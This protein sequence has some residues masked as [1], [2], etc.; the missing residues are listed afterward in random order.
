MSSNRNKPVLT[1]PAGIAVYPSLNKPDTKFDNAGKYKVKVRIPKDD[2]GAFLK[3]LKKLYTD[4]YKAQCEKEGKE[5]KKAPVPWTIVEE[6]G[7]KTG[8]IMFNFAMKARGTGRD[9]STWEN[10]PKIFGP[11]ASL[12]ANDA[13]PNI[14]GG[15]KMKVNHMVDGWYSAAI[16]AGI[17][18]RIR[19]VQIIELVEWGG[20]SSASDFGFE[21]EG[22]A[23]E[24]KVTTSTEDDTFE[25]TSDADF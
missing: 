25:D 3:E 22:E 18:L 9:G 6:D 23:I 16:G 20:G 14:G 7:K 10:R 8:E 15:T 1:C 21:S 4:N 11:D 24:T 5:L 2:C 12:L 13:L 19:G 17:S